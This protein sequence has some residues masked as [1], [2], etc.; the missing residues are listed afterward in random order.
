M[1]QLGTEQDVAPGG[2]TPYYYAWYEMLPAAETPLPYLVK[3]G[4]TITASLTCI[5]GCSSKKQIWQL[6][7]SDPAENWS[8]SQTFSYSSSL[9][10]AESIEEAPYQ[11]G[12]LP[13]AEFG[14][15]SFSATGGVKNGQTPS[16][17][18]ATNGLQMQDPWG[19]TANPS[20][21]TTLADFDAC[22]GF[23]AFTSCPAP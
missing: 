2:A 6:T 15:A 8:W 21:A 5:S 1:I 16:L 3:P 13:L 9:L 20:S 18:V 23:Q 7:M 22:W 12:I 10:S 4:D 17:S 19:Q 14:T 11:G